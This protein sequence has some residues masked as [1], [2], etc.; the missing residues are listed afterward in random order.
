MTA[1]TRW[2]ALTVELRS[3]LMAL[4]LARPDW[5]TGIAVVDL[6]AAIA[7]FERYAR[8]LRRLRRDE[9][10]TIPMVE[11]ELVV[12]APGKYEAAARAIDMDRAFGRVTLP[13]QANGKRRG[14]VEARP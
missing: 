5:R 11:A 12:E 9:L 10:R 14:K 3:L 4:G 8:E 2:L 6:D 1:S 13:R 7:R